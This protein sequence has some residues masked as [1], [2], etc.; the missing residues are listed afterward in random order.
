MHYLDLTLPSAAG[1]LAADEA[2]LDWCEAG[3]AGEIVS[4]WEP[5]AA[6]V[7]LGYAN[8]VAAEVNLP[9][10]EQ[11]GVPIFRRCTGGGTVV[12]LPGGLNYSL[13]LRITADGPTRSISSANAFIMERNRAAVQAALGAPELT[14]TVRGHTDLAVASPAAPGAWLK[15]AGN[16]QRRRRHFLLFHGT[17]LLD[18]NLPRIGELLRMPTLEPD[19]RAGR[20][21]HDFVTNLRLPPAAVKA[22]LREAWGADAPL[23]DPPLKEIEKL[24]QEKY[25]TH[26]WNYKF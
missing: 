5:P 13:I 25:V 22:A 8:R 9:A 24:A 7:V 18:C 19:Y 16:A 23:A 10:C 11:Q 17:L 12:Q 14:V 21:H 15:V 3:H 6:F 1:L 20:A 2:L 26:A 4:F